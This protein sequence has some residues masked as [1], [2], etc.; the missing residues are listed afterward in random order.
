[1]NKACDVVSHGYAWVQLSQN[2][3]GHEGLG[4]HIVSTCRVAY[5]RHV[6]LWLLSSLSRGW[7]LA[8]K[9]D[10]ASFEANSH[11]SVNRLSSIVLGAGHRCVL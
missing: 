7:G 1:M 10:S 9:L 8:L 4:A 6:T 2:P 5:G 11:V 3:P